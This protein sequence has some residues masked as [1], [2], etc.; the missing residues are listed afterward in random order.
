ML[1]K[2]FAITS[3]IGLHAR[4]AAILVSLAGGYQSSITMKYQDKTVPLSSLIAVMT[5]GVEAGKNVEISISGADQAQ[6]MERMEQ[7]FEKEL[8]DL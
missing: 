5:L 4:P 2:T 1:T 8:K 3:A 6:A 7:F